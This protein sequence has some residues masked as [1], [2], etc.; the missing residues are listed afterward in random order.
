MNIYIYICN[1]YIYIHIYVSFFRRAVQ[2]V[3]P[4]ASLK[5]SP[6]STLLSVRLVSKESKTNLTSKQ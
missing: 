1:I 2:G 5:L 6:K 4:H 3:W